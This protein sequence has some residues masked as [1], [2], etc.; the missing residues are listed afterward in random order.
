MQ[1]TASVQKKKQKKKQMMCIS[2]QREIIYSYPNN[3]FV[4]IPK[5]RSD[6]TNKQIGDYE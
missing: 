1:E 5:R 4:Y 2:V 6:S 3:V